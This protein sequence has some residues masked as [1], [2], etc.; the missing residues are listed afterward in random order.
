MDETL[1]RKLTIMLVEDDPV[2]FMAFSSYVDLIDD[3]RLIGVT[4]NA[5]KALLFNRFLLHMDSATSRRM[6]SIL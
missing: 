5:S 3:V 2:A 4:N 1:E 6:T